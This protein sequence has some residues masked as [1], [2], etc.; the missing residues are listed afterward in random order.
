MENTGKSKLVA[1]LVKWATQK[2]TM[3]DVEIMDDEIDREIE[4]QREMQ[5]L[6]IGS[7]L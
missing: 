6:N 3:A 1:L 5:E 2:V 4:R 7:V